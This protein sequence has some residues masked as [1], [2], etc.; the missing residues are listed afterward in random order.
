VQED[1][2]EPE[3]EEDQ[4]AFARARTGLDEDDEGDDSSDDERRQLN[5]DYDSDADTVYTSSSLACA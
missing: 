4:A 3:T 5:K 1:R 2:F